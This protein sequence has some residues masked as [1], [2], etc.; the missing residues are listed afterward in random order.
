MAVTPKGYWA[1]SVNIK[2]KNTLTP[3]SY[4]SNLQSVNVWNIMCGTPYVVFRL[5]DS[6][7]AS[8]GQRIRCGAHTHTWAETVKNKFTMDRVPVS[9]FAMTTHQF[10]QFDYR[11][12]E[13]Y[14]GKSQA[15]IM[16]LHTQTPTLNRDSNFDIFKKTLILTT[17]ICIGF[18]GGML[19]V[20]HG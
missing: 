8:S 11:Q 4:I 5:P 14:E 9:S 10:Q 3:D 16:F 20:S 7:K 17:F 19:W 15:S 18:F 12:E 13:E 1:G 2:V 6:I